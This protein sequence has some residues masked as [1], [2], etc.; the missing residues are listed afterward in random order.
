ML[1]NKPT[2]P[3]SSKYIEVPDGRMHYFDEGAGPVILFVHGIPEWSMTYSKM[4]EELSSSFRSIV[5]DHLGFGL[6]DKRI[7][8]DLKPAAHSARLLQF[9]ERLGLS[10]IHLVVHDFGGPI[11]IGALAQ[12]P[13]LFSS[14]TISNTW[15]WNL[16]GTKAGAGLKMMQGFF[17]KWLYL[18]Y[19]FSVKYMAKNAFADKAQFVQWKDVFM[20][21]HQTKLDRLANYQ[22]MLEMLNS[23]KWYD[24]TLAAFKKLDIPAQFAWGMKDKFFPHEEYLERWKKELPGK[25]IITLEASGHFPQLEVPKEFAAAIKS[26]IG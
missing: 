17:G 14:L 2:L 4:I 19:G 16:A 24:S 12:K 18:S 13:E 11:G 26:F 3:F 25:K 6:S 10:N 15:L 20:Y 8:I 7:D 5:P 9:I 23:G 21:P 1:V 22:L